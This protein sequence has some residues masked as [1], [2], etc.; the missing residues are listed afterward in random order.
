MTNQAGTAASLATPAQ[1]F[2]V[3]MQ[4]ISQGFADVASAAVEAA[5]PKTSSQ[6]VSGSDSTKLEKLIDDRFAKVLEAQEKQLRLTEVQNQLLA[7]LLATMQRNQHDQP[8]SS[9]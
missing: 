5:R 8:N 1:L 3:G 9:E 7:Q 4:A 2:D 6:S